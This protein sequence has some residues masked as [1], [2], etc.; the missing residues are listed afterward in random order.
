MDGT[1]Q[2]WSS[3]SQDFSAAR[4]DMEGPMLGAASGQVADG[5][6]ADADGRGADADGNENA[7][8]A[9]GATAKVAAGVAAGAAVEAAEEP[10]AEPSVEVDEPGALT[11][12]FLADMEKINRKRQRDEMER[13]E[14]LHVLDIQ[15]RLNAQKVKH[16]EVFFQAQQTIKQQNV[17]IST[18]QD[19]ITQQNK[20]IETHLATIAT[21]AKLQQQC[22]DEQRRLEQENTALRDKMQSSQDLC[23]QLHALMFPVQSLPHAQQGSLPI[24]CRQEAQ[25]MQA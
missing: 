16:D 18:H 10:T 2:N 14:N 1:Q 23:A 8:A 21:H 9:V 4:I 11:R 13:L 24:S 5:R 20:D 3:A 6:G 22:Q 19:K 12:K 15:K 17:E 25:I 7:A